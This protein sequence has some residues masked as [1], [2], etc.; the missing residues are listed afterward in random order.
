[1]VGCGKMGSSMLAQ[2]R[3]KRPAELVKLYVIEPHN[4]PPRDMKSMWV[5]TLKFLPRNVRP[6]I[7]V[8]AVKPQQLASILPSYRR[9]FGERPLYVS[10]AAGKPIGFFAGHLG[11]RARIV[12]AMPNTP[13]LVGESMTVLCAPPS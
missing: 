8:F 6:N 4:E 13:A 2:W 11:K 3:K 12:R 9:R 1:L 10:I 5:A 7:I